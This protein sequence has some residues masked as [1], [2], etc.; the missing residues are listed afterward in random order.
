MTSLYIFC[1]LIICSVIKKI[2]CYIFLCTIKYSS[3]PPV[4]FNRKL[5]FS[6]LPFHFTPCLPSFHNYI[7]WQQS[8]SRV[9]GYTSNLN[10]MCQRHFALSQAA[11]GT[12]QY[13][14]DFD[15][16]EIELR[17]KDFINKH[18][19]FTPLSKLGTLKQPWLPLINSITSPFAIFSK[20]YIPVF[21]RYMH[22]RW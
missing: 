20:K 12:L 17:L 4:S 10:L 13:K 11:G 14:T 18:P 5:L 6:Y 21:S 9:S 15:A 2:I 16:M 3:L 19:I 22:N 8:S 7:P 1:V